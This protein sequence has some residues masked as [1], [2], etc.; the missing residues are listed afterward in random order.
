MKS[1][2]VFYSLEGH[3]KSIADIIQKELNCDLLELKPE[4]EIPKT[5]IRKFFWG[6][7]KSA[8]FNEKPTLKN[9]IPNLN[10]YD[11]IFIG[12]PI[13]AGKYT[14]AINTFIS[15]NKIK[16]KNIGFLHVMVEVVQ[17]SVFK[18]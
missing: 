2:I 11:A 15:Q 4:K 16:G 18:N 10:G 14:P 7:G 8:I 13:W 6:G 9:Q 17:K 1:L 5:G 3:T 12:T